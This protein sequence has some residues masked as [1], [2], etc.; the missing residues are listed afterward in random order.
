MKTFVCLTLLFAPLG[1][2]QEPKEPMVLMPWQP[3]PKEAPLFF[4]ATAE[5]TARVGLADVTSDQQ[6]VFR[7]HQGR[8]EV[9]SLGLSGAGEIVAVTGEGLRDWSVR[10]AEHGVRF[11]DL[12]PLLAEGKEAKPP[13][14]LKVLVKTRFAFAD[15]AGGTA[16]LVLPTPGAA[17]GLALNLT[18]TADP[19]VEQRVTK[20]EGLLPVESQ[21]GRKFVGSAV[22]VAVVEVEVTPGGSGARGLDL[23]D[24]QVLGK[25]AAD[26]SSVTFSLTG[27]ASAAAEGAAVE[28]FEGGALASGVAGDGW[29]VALRKVKESYVY[30]L[31]AERAGDFPVALEFEVPV[32]RKGDWRALEFRLPAGVVVPLRMDGL[33]KGVEFHRGMAVVPEPDGAQSRGFL[34]V[35]GAATLAWRVAGAVADGALFF[36]ST[37]TTD[38]RVGS[39]LLRQLTVLDLRVLQGKLAELALA[40]SG[41]GEVLSVAGETVL[42]WEVKP[43][44]QGT[45]R[46]EVKLN[47]P[48]D[49]TA[50]LVIESQAALGGFPLR[51]ETLRMSPVGVLRHSGWLRVANEGAVRIEVSDAKGLIQLA[52]GQFPGGADEKLRQVFAYRFP[53]ADYSYAIQAD[54]V[55][56]EVAVTEV[57]VYELAE[58]D[59]RVFSEIELDIR[60]APL[61]E[62]EMEIPADHAVASVTGAAVG[63]YVVASEAKD[64]QRR[65]KV[66]FKQAV[67][68]RQ[69]VS[70]RLEKNEAA[71]AGAWELPPLGFPAV[72]SRRGYVGA[73]AAAGYRLVAG[74]TAG[75]AEVPITFFPKQ[76]AGLQQAFRLRESDWTVGLAVEALGQSVQADVFHLYSLKAGAAYGSV[77]INYFVVGA[78]AT[79]WKIAVPA[80]IGNIDVTGQNVGRDWRKEENTVIVPLSRPVLGTGTVLLTFELPMNAQG[81]E[82]SPGEVRPLGVQGERGYVQVVSPL[83]VNY[84]VTSSEGP[85]LVIDPS[86][87]PAEFRLLSSAPTLAAWQYTGRD[88][89]IGMGIKW[90]APGETAAQVVDFLKLSSQV[91]RDGEWVTD[92]RFFVKSRG[93]N[94]LRVTLPEKGVLWEAKVGSEAVNARQDGGETLIPLPARTD[95]KQAVEVSLRYGA[96]AKNP[97]RLRLIAPKLDAPVVIGEWAI[98]GDEGRQLVPRGGTAELVRPALAEDG[99][100]WIASRSGAAAS[101]IL[102]VGAA[103]ALGRGTPGKARRVLALV[104]GLVVIL[105]ALGLAMAAVGSMRGSSEELEYAAPVVAAGGEVVVDIGN[106]APWRA[107]TSWGVWLGLVLGT[108]VLLRGGLAR[109]PWWKTCGLAL[110]GAGVLAIHGGTPLFFLVVAVA[111]AWWWLPRVWQLVGD[112]RKPRLVEAAAAVLILTGLLPGDGR[113]AEIPGVKPAEA[114]IHEWQIHEGRL[115]GTVDVTVRGQAGDRFLLLRAPA[116]L[117]GFE[118]TGLRVVKAPLDGQDAYFIVAEVAGRMTGKAVFEMPLADP[119]KGWNLPGGAAAMRRITVR[120]DQPGWEFF[121]PHAAKVTAIDGLAAT[122]SGAVLV[123]GPAD[124]VTIQARA[125][126]RDVGAEETRF[127]AEVSNLFLPGPGVVNGRHRVALRPAQGRVAALVMKVPEG[128]TVSDVANGPVGSWRFDPGTRELRVAVEPAQA[129]AFALTIE[130]QR[131]A[132]TLPM[133]L[134]LEPLRVVGAAVEIGFLALAFG[135]EAQPERV[136]VVGLSRLNPEDFKAELLPRDKDGQPL[137]LLQHAF[138]YGSGEVKATVKVTAVAPEL[139]AE[140]WQLVSLGDD[141]LLVA[142]DLSVTITR[143]GVFRLA[144]EVPAG[145]EIESATGE[146]LSHWTESKAGGKRVVTLHLT[147][148]TIGKRDFNL[149]LTGPPPGAQATWVVPRLTVLEASRETGDLTVVP[150]RGLQ[151]RAVHRKNISQAD[152]R[153]LV[154]QPKASARAAARPGALAYRLLESDWALSLAIDKLDSWV[155]AQVFHEATLREGQMLSRVVLGYRIDNAAVKALRVRIPGLDATAAATVRASGAAVADLVPVEGKEGLWEIRFQRGVAGETSVELE[156]QRRSKDDGLEQIEP[157]ELEQVR[158]VVYFTAVRAAGRLEL[159]PGILPRGWQRADWAVVQSTLGQAAGNVAPLMAFRVADPEGPLPVKLKRLKLADLQRLRVAAGLLTTLLSPTG[160]AL[161]AVDLQMEVVGKGTLKLKLPKGAELYNVLVNDEGATLVRERDEWLFYVFPAPETGMPATVRFVYSAG[162][163]QPIRLEGPVLNVPMEKLTWQ[164]L[165]PEGWRM[166]GHQGDFDL[167]QQDVRASFRLDDYKK[168]SVSKRKTDSQRASA[169]L[170]QANSYLQQGDQEKASQALGN[171]VRSNQLDEATNED[172]RVLQYKTKTQQAV[173]GLNTR[174]QRVVLDNRLSAPQADTTQLDR[175]AAANPLMQ[176]KQN[177]DPKQFDRL[178]EGNTADENAA[179]KEIANR[180]VSQQLAAEPA[181]LALD[182]TLPERGTVLTFWRSVQVDGKRPMSIT[183]DLKRSGTGF[184]WLALVLCLLAG[185][186]VGLRRRR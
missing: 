144:L 32:T 137:V 107:M 21:V 111:A 129:Q 56:P 15:G 81:G 102:L 42:G 153:D 141:R 38:V 54:Q 181:P 167:K 126:Q 55:M 159:E 70:L 140:S 109:D 59:R 112:L 148:K 168:F 72:K 52:P 84:E 143:S 94:A 39:G 161:T 96:R 106:V 118:G 71:K 45:R 184:S 119:V 44:A 79:E 26:G 78:P 177:F 2:C 74:K 113:A 105:F 145:L 23:L 6:L 90:F 120:W 122:A 125:K 124:A 97:Q 75:V 180:L 151:V 183:L 115:R 58:T 89:K 172:A 57:T 68:G 50:R 88:F 12:R 174:R 3:V 43:G 27:Q 185:S 127:Y 67:A 33:G 77:L 18:I 155:T 182:V 51:T 133:E 103:L 173:L 121:S 157:L 171:A 131:G 139:R 47:Q 80:G 150:E 186:M 14:E 34:P 48:I 29:H 110:I 49:G 165:V 163:G 100:A 66:I 40:L 147:G 98:R 30:D 28:L 128:F 11:L 82:V 135:D 138:Q 1:L 156:Y 25:V 134:E 108:G 31:V 5:V 154:E 61:R 22:A 46:L 83:Q 179:L 91:S 8:P 73:V 19:G 16:A 170:D 152:P 35:S 7:V 114:M 116:V 160:Q 136:E 9:L 95:S 17:T 36:S 69:L 178:L 13:G 41:P 146:G 104:C 20:A 158:Q 85:L 132:G 37:E 93:R 63:D 164:V 65:L 86:E 87:L 4:S 24:A 166:T 176:G 99:F 60:E 117:S 64:G 162:T 149:T 101:L 175:A 169:L 53:A 10:V 142:T 62:W 92:A 76:T 123:L 130:T